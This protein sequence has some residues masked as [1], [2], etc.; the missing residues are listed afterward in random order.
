MPGWWGRPQEWTGTGPRQWAG[1]WVSQ[2]EH[3]V[4]GTQR[5]ASQ[6][7]G[8]QWV[9][10]SDRGGPGEGLCFVQMIFSA[11]TRD[12]LVGSCGGRGDLEAKAGG[13]CLG[14]VTRWKKQTAG[15]L[16]ASPRSLQGA[17]STPRCEAVTAQARQAGGRIRSDSARPS[18]ASQGG[19]P[20]T[21]RCPLSRSHSRS[22]KRGLWGRSPCLLQGPILP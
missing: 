18:G 16:V 20:W 15:P 5:P 17:L 12:H 19:A 3:D 7:Q 6:G 14:Q 21:G 10:F 4:S 22:A 13:S 1:P 11:G 8:A 2:G 9:A